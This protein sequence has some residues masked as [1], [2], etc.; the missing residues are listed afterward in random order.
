MEGLTPLKM[1]KAWNSLCPAAAHDD[2][3]RGIDIIVI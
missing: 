2:G 3:D 1:Q